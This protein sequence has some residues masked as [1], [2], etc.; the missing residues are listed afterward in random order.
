MSLRDNPQFS[1]LEIITPSKSYHAHK[2]VLSARSS[3]WGKGQDLSSAVLDWRPFSEETCEDLIDY[4]YTDKVNCLEDK[5]Y[6]D[7]RIIKLLGAASFFSLSELM[8][9]CE[10]SLEESKERYLLPMDSPAVLMKVALQASEKN[11][12]KSN[13]RSVLKIN[14]QTKS[15]SKKGVLEDS[16]HDHNY[17]GL[18]IQRKKSFKKKRLKKIALDTGENTDDDEENESAGQVQ[19][20][21][22]APRRTNFDKFKLHTED[23]LFPPNPGSFVQRC[24]GSDVKEYYQLIT[25]TKSYYDRLP[26]MPVTVS[27][28][29][30]NSVTQKH[31]HGHFVLKASDEV[32]SKME[33]LR[34]KQKLGL[35]E[36]FL[37]TE[38]P[39]TVNFEEELQKKNVEIFVNEDSLDRA[40]DSLANKLPSVNLHNSSIC[41]V[42]VK[43]FEVLEKKD[44][45]KAGDL[46]SLEDSVIVNELSK[47]LKTI[48]VGTL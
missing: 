21:C 30:L 24:F 14:N 44:L 48:E 36:S 6:D 33:L 38:L 12:K 15:K 8:E 28:T 13:K 23:E 18:N 39:R 4:L 34:S 42:N 27:D 5:L 35:N 25:D 43:L 40:E 19:A 22:D 17:L 11:L 41:N 1:D 20:T 45:S 29:V 7:L 3:D 10:R 9:R 32:N 47:V 37:T 31:E 2:L 26:Q 16:M 46:F